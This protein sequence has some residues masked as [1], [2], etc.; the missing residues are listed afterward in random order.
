M[1]VGLLL[2]FVIAKTFNLWP[3]SET[4]DTAVLIGTLIISL[5]PILL[6]LVDIIVE[7]GGVIE[8][9]GLKIDL[10]HVPH[11]GGGF[12]VPSNIG[13]PGKAVQDS[14]TTNILDALRDATESE[15]VVID[16]EDGRA[17]WETRLLVL[18]AGAVKL[19][20]PDR[21]VFVGRESA[22]EKCFQGWGAASTLLR[23]LLKASPEYALSYHKAV[24][25][26]RQWELV[27]P[28]GTGNAPAW[29][30]GL[31]TQH[32]WMAFDSNTK[33]PNLLLLPQLLAA[34]LGAII[35]SQEA[36]KPINLNRLEELFGRLLH[37]DVIDESWPAER[38]ARA[39]FDSDSP[40]LA[41]TRNREY[42]T[43]MS[44][45]SL[46]NVAVRNLIEKPP[47]T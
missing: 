7:R 25:A 3:I 41:V 11:T 39:F 40:Y 19:G 6:S 44:R 36:P 2:I 16:L 38:Q 34:D 21:L 33:L 9:G 18:L 10:S 8:G 24:A 5:L 4:S 45:A 35:E 43:L 15:V 37:M 29:M 17:W 23:R 32:P 14:D 31:A 12:K 13:V 20:R 47:L 22:T 46:L 30:T 27:E 26:S 42:S 1:L 28:P